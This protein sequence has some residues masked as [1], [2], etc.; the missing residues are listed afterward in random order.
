MGVGVGRGKLPKWS[1][2]KWGQLKGRESQHLSPAQPGYELPKGDDPPAPTQDLEFALSPAGGGVGNALSPP[3][4][5]TVPDSDAGEMKRTQSCPQ[6]AHRPWQGQMS[7]FL[8][9]P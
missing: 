1:L 8:T 4:P 6:G 5:V 7:G 2:G 3:V 9:P